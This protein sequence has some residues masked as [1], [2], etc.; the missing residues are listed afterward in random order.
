MYRASCCKAE[1]AEVLTPRVVVCDCFDDFYNNLNR[2][3]L[4]CSMQAITFLYVK[5]IKVSHFISIQK[6]LFSTQL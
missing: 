5:V 6:Y 4:L 1:F 2:N 3:A